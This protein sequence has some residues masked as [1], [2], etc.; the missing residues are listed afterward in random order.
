MYTTI[1][2]IVTIAI[3]LGSSL[4]TYSIHTFKDKDSLLSL[5]ALS[6]MVNYC[7]P[8]TKIL[9]TNSGS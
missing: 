1:P 4:H 5:Q 6:V 3:N 9:H 7:D 8:I 2:G